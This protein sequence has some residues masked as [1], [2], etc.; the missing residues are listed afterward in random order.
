[1]RACIDIT[2]APLGNVT[3]D[4]AGD[5]V[6][7]SPERAP[8]VYRFAMKRGGWRGVY[9][10]EADV[11]TRRFQHYRK[12]GPTQYTNIRIHEQIADTLGSGGRVNV[13]VAYLGTLTID[14]AAVTLDL[15]TKAGRALAESAL[16]ADEIA[17]GH[18]EILNL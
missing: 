14:G 18:G 17:R 1:M 12:P 5:Q 8:G 7:P 16:L 10:G 3:I 4:S 13:D 11:M 6:F 15:T 2:L 9:I